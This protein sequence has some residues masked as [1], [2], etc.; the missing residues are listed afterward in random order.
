MA[1]TGQVDFSQL[2]LHLKH[3][4]RNSSEQSQPYTLAEVPAS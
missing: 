1:Y 4:E 3:L 2:R